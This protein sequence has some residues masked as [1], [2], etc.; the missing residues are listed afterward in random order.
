METKK[1]ITAN[2]ITLNSLFPSYIY[3]DF[4]AVILDPYARFVWSVH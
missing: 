1:S 4:G 2:R 3:D